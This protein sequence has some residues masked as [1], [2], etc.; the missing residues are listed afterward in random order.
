MTLM[1]DYYAQN[2]RRESFMDECRATI[3][4]CAQDGT[5]AA[6]RVILSQL[7]PDAGKVI[8]EE[9]LVRLAAEN[10]QSEMIE[11]LLQHRANI[12][13]DTRGTPAAAAAAFCK[14]KAL[15][16]LLRRDASLLSLP[17][18]QSETTLLHEITAGTSSQMESELT[19]NLIK[20]EFCNRF[21]RVVDNFDDRGLTALHQAVIWSSGANVENLLL[22]GATDCPVRGTTVTTTGLAQLALEQPPWLIAQQGHRR[23]EKYK[24]EVETYIRVLGRLS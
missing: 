14:R 15:G 17:S 3:R 20:E 7:S 9:E 5:I 22:L 21:D 16:V 13:H 11:L 8:G 24:H 4:A 19:M 6:G 2:L 18:T 23:V 12:D 1:S 10:D